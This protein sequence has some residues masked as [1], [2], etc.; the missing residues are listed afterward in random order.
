MRTAASHSVRRAAAGALLVL[1]SL[2]G[3]SAASVRAQA[4]AEVDLAA[5]DRYVEEQREAQRVP[6]IALG[7]VRDG[8]IVHLRGFGVA[9]SS[10]RALTAET[11]FITGSLSKSFTAVAIMQLAERDALDL[12]AP[13]QR[14]LPWF[15]V[16]DSEASERITLRHLLYQTSGLPARAGNHGIVDGDTSDAALER[17]VRA[18]R[19]I[20]LAN[21]VGLIHVYS[22]ANYMTLGLVVQ[23]V[24]GQ[25]YDD[26]VQEHIFTPLGMRQSFASKDAARRAGLASGHRYWFG[27][28]VPADLP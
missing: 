27:V 7:I 19:S 6:G 21:P 23:A 9:D 8:E 25:S 1:A 20:E 15:R 11:P 3:P 24:A 16:A 13:V 12:D 22:N 14:Y 26:Y 4:A 28:P 17:Q 5:I 2:V 18:L 10:G